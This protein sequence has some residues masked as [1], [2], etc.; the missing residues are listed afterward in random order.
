MMPE[1]YQP[2]VGD[3]V[4]LRYDDDNTWGDGVVVAAGPEQSEWRADSD[5]VERCAMNENLV[6]V[7]RPDA[8]RP[9]LSPRRQVRRVN[10]SGHPN[11]ARLS[12]GLAGNPKRE[13]SASRDHWAKVLDH[14][15]RGATIGELFAAGGHPA[16]LRECLAQGYAKIVVDDPASGK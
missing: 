5:R 6:L 11:E 2:K 13:G 15:D 7:D 10:R 16:A 14:A 9:V 1:P 8:A 3:R 4:R 12:R